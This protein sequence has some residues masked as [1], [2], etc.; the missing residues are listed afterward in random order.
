MQKQQKKVFLKKE[1]KNKFKKYKA[2]KINIRNILRVTK[3]SRHTQNIFNFMRLNNFK[4]LVCKKVLVRFTSNNIFLTLVD[5]SNKRTLHVG[6][7]GKYNIK[8]SKKKIKFNSKS[9][10]LTFFKEISSL[11]S[12][13][14]E[15]FINIIGPVRVK[16]ILIKQVKMFFKETRNVFIKVDPK[17][18]F[19]GCRP[20]K[21]IRKRKKGIR[22]FKK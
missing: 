14:D 5:M 11:L 13:K 15:I 21:K 17:K 8:T 19:N 9:V 1:F 6:S 18:C 4:P 12:I 22:L 10:L 20:K 2:K 7:G 16:K 3:I